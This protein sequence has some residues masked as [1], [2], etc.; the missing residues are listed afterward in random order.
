VS[1]NV[2]SEYFVIK[3]IVLFWTS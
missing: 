3:V 1:V 2:L